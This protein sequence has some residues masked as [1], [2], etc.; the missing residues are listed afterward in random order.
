MYGFEEVPKGAPDGSTW[1]G[2]VHQLNVSFQGCIHGS[3]GLG[4]NVQK[5]LTEEAS[6]HLCMWDRKAF[7]MYN[8]PAAAS[9]DATFRK[10]LHHMFPFCACWRNSRECSSSLSFCLAVLLFVCPP[11]FRLVLVDFSSSP[12]SVFPS[13]SSL[14]PPLCPRS[15]GLLSS[16]SPSPP[17]YTRQLTPQWDSPTFG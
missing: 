12:L 13:F 2:Y 3:S 17:T 15:L 11:P 6:M 4:S 14:L 10:D 8:G 7:W 16:P 5:I 1:R 9:L